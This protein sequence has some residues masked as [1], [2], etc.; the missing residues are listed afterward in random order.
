MSGTHPAPKPRSRAL[1]A[2]GTVLLVV[3]VAL[4][5]WLTGA[6][7]SADR[8]ASG[9]TLATSLSAPPASPAATGPAAAPTAQPTTAQ[10]TTV[11]PDRVMRTLALIDAGLWPEAAQAPGT[12]GGAT[13]RNNE[14]RLPTTGADGRRLRFQEWDVNPKKPHRG[15]DAERVVTADDGSA[16]FTLDHY[17]SFTQI[18]GPAR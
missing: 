9:G 10:Q 2:V 15:R 8:P 12:R 3:A 18:R 7:D 17:R 14:R 16:W 5:W 1:A 13:F 6:S 4:A 11:A